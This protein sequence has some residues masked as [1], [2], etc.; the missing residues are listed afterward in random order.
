[1]WQIVQDYDNYYDPVDEKLRVK[2]GVKLPDTSKETIARM[3]PTQRVGEW[4]GV[5]VGRDLSHFVL[6]QKKEL[7]NSSIRRSL[8]SDLAPEVL[9]Q[10]Y[11]TLPNG[12]VKNFLNACRGT[13][14]ALKERLLYVAVVGSKA[15]EGSGIWHKYYAIWLSRHVPN[16]VIDFIDY[17]ERADDWV[18]VSETS[19]LSCEWIVE[20]MTREDLERRGYNV[21]I[22]DVW[23]YETG[24]GIGPVSA[25]YFSLKGTAN[26]DGYQPYLHQVETRKFSHPPLAQKA[27]C[28]C[29]TCRECLACSVDYDDYILLRHLC[30]RLGHVTQCIGVSFLNDLARVS[31]MVRE[32]RMKP[33]VDVQ[34]YAV[35]RRIMAISEEISLDFSGA[36]VSQG[37]GQAEFLQLRRKARELKGTFER[38]IYPDFVGKR[39]LFCGVPS[40]ILGS[41]KIETISGAHSAVI[42]DYVFCANV[43]V[44]QQQFS[45]ATVYCP[46]GIQYARDHFPDW[47]YT[48]KD[49]QGYKEFKRRIEVKP[50][51]LD[52][53]SPHQLWQRTCF[54]PLDIAPFV[55]SS[56]LS[57]PLEKR[58]K[59]VLGS[60][61]YSLSFN[62]SYFKVIRFRRELWR[63]SIWV[64]GPEWGPALD[65]IETL[66]RGPGFCHVSADIYLPWDMTEGEFYGVEQR[67]KVAHH[68]YVR[69]KFDNG[70]RSFRPQERI[71][72]GSFIETWSQF[73]GRQGEFIITGEL[74][75]ILCRNSRT[76]PILLIRSDPSLLSTWQIA[77]ALGFAAYSKFREV[78]DLS[79]VEDET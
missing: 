76:L 73:F 48:G 23:S 25:P 78:L 41:T 50:L 60:Q 32:I 24:S 54:L 56:L 7:L 46:I 17:K 33:I 21:I 34:I 15:A 52:K 47:E 65:A 10:T 29:M 42:C 31:E 35:F 59:F 44:W 37:Q 79:S 53:T 43:E 1:M 49:V 18:Q 5:R 67:L 55:D 30:V 71:T 75:N 64:N 45:S 4:G 66:G 57:A 11:L 40:T 8:G 20:G 3:Y 26:Q 51:Q 22:D 38:I 12:Q 72:I 74:R 70:D 9:L 63:Q 13:V 58:G 69:K 77:S 6:P 16:V 36:Q 27:A 68:Q 28:Y 14:G 62:S 2:N 39:V 61:F 19:F